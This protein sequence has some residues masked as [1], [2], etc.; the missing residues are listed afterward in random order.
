LAA[1]PRTPINVSD[2]P[3]AVAAV[4]SYKNPPRPLPVP[5]SKGVGAALLAAGTLLTTYGWMNW[6]R[7]YAVRLRAGALPVM[8]SARAVRVAPTAIVNPPSDCVL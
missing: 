6:T 4:L 5:N 8:F 2:D 3:V 1:P 7:S